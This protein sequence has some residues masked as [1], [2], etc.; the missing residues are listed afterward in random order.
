MQ[1]FFNEEDSRQ[2]GKFLSNEV[3]KICPIYSWRRTN[4]VNR[5]ELYVVAHGKYMTI[6]LMLDGAYALLCFRTHTSGPL[7]VH[8]FISDSGCAR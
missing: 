7:R 4:A 2:I 6:F 8:V 5:S 3:F 1:G